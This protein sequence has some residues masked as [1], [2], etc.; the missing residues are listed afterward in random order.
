M[1]S[2]KARQVLS[3]SVL[4]LACW[5][6]ATA[7]LPYRRP[8]VFLGL[9]LRGPATLFFLPN[10]PPRF[11]FLRNAVLD[12]AHPCLGGRLTFCFLLFILGPAFLFSMTHC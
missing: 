10:R 7:Q 1:T 2:D 5:T 12:T 4:V 9:A 3:S 8:P 6:D 11:P